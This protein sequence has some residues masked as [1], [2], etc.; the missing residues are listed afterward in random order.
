MRRQG[1][2][3]ARGEE[4]SEENENIETRKRKKQNHMKERKIIINDK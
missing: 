3:R 4:K 2:R 1:K